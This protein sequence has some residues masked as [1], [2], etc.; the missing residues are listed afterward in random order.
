MSLRFIPNAVFCAGFLLRPQ[1]AVLGISS[2][3][4]SVQGEMTSVA[5]SSYL[6]RLRPQGRMKAFFVAVMRYRCSLT[7]A[8][9]LT[10]P[11]LT[12]VGSLG[13]LTGEAWARS[14][15]WPRRCSHTRVH[16]WVGEGSCWRSGLWCPEPGGGCSLQSAEALEYLQIPRPVHFIYVFI[17]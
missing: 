16:E 12:W 8:A 13:G 1:A 9:E 7:G 5:P 6:F 15:C 10:H 11:S 2:P 17:F 4:P 3:R 14:L